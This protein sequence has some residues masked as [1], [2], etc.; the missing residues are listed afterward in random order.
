MALIVQK[1]DGTEVETRFIGAL[2]IEGVQI[3][4]HEMSLDHF[5][6]MAGHFLSGGFF[7]WPNNETPEAINETL[8]Q[9]FEIYE[10]VDGKWIRKEKYR[11]D[12]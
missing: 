11:V 7:G 2:P 5:G 12:I 9:L 10:Q 3:G 6:S 1:M 4:E 8:S